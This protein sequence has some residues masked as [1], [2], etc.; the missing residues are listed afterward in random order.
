MFS[1]FSRDAASFEANDLYD[2][3]LEELVVKWTE[4]SNDEKLARSVVLTS[5]QAGWFVDRA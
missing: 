3:S 4:A 1:L 2:K 5:S